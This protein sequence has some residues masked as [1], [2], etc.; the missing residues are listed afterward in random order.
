MEKVA[1][2]KGRNLNS[3]TLEEMDVLWEAAKSGG[4]G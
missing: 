3:L 4:G 2:E 1:S